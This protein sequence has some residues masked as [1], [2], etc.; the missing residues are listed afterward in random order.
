LISREKVY[1]DK[2]RQWN[3]RRNLNESDVKVA[4]HLFRQAKREKRICQL[5][6]REQPVSWE[7]IEA[8]LSKNKKGT[9]SLLAESDSCNVIPS[10]ITFDFV[11]SAAT[12]SSYSARPT[13]SSLVPVTTSSHPSL[14]SSPNGSHSTKTSSISDLTSGLFPNNGT[15]ATTSPR[16]NSENGSHAGAS[17]EAAAV[18]P[19]SEANQDHLALRWKSVQAGMLARGELAHPTPKCAL[20][21]V[22]EFV[23]H[24]VDAVDKTVEST[25]LLDICRLMSV[26]P[27][28][29]SHSPR[30]FLT[31]SSHTDSSLYPQDHVL[32][33]T[34]KVELPR[35]GRIGNKSE[36]HLQSRPDAFE[37]LD[38]PS[39]FLSWSIWACLRKNEGMDDQAEMAL[40]EA[41]KM[42]QKMVT[43]RYGKCLTSLNL[44]L[45]VFEAHGQREIA[46]EL[47]GKLCGVL[48][49]LKGIP[50]K[51]SVML[52]IRF[53]KD[54]M[55][56]VKI[57]QMSDPSTLR[58]IHYCF[59][60]FWGPESPSTLACQFNL[61]WRLA[62]DK[63]T[64]RL[65][66]G[67]D[68]LS[69]AR[70]GLE[71]VLPQNDPQTITCMTV[72]ARVLYNLDRHPEALEMMCTAMNRINDRFPEYHPYRLSALRRLSIFMQKVR[73][74]NPEPILREVA[75][76]RMRALGPDCELTQA[77]T[78]ELS[79][80]LK[81]QGRDND[82]EDVPRAVREVALRLDCGQNIYQLF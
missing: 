22:Q 64:E 41:A 27:P 33:D 38:C 55:S 81:K 2:L 9:K 51:D 58:N 52:T 54:I 11:D 24:L 1:K 15:V 4:L 67:L 25:H 20:R 16:H 7:R 17:I 82:V 42:F 74:G 23:E 48:L 14:E 76:R 68:V 79:A 49:P 35:P 31:P 3:I 13:P 57:E 39:H 61:G 32:I 43:H 77:S 75:A 62:G 30:Q 26:T 34:R 72:L 69:R 37:P 80:F 59:E 56:G 73:I 18:V 29:T 28:S 5:Y 60:R 78:K 50:E 70:D 66:E 46:F 12:T 40:K 21:T 8:Y 65:K 6:I 47:L 44:L 10:H 53:K 63:D 71:R 36:D 19:L 45:A